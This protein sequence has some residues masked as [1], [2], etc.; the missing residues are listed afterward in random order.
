MSQKNQLRDALKQFQVSKGKGPNRETGHY[1][2]NSGRQ[3]EKFIEWAEGR[4]VESFEDIRRR[5]VQLFREYARRL[6]RRDVKPSTIQTYWNYLSAWTG[7]CVREGH[8]PSNY[9]QLSAAK[10][11]L[12][13]T[14][15]SER[16]DEQ[17]WTDE[18]RIELLRY[19]DQQAHDA[20]DKEGYAALVPARDR[21]LAYVLSYTGIRGAELLRDPDDARRD[22]LTW[23]D[24]HLDDSRVD[25]LSKKQ[26]H[27]ERALPPQTH[28]SLE[29][30][31]RVLSPA[32]EQWPVF[33][34]A[35]TSALRRSAR[36]QLET[37]ADPL[38]GCSNAVELLEV[39]RNFDLVPPSLSTSGARSVMRRLTDDAGI[40]V[41]QADYLQPHG[42]RRGAG[43]VLV[44]EEGVDAA[45]EQLDNSARVVEEHYSDILTEEQADRTG[46]AFKN[47]E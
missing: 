13:E 28:A 37:D 18:Q 39:Y 16:K 15:G 46:S 14:D 30:L 17:S 4:G 11:P 42:A 6:A 24:I 19:C 22:G 21:A 9:A 35:D 5:G 29:R 36:E 25:V 8:L 44:L 32:S 41:S 23:V 3:V 33:P 7:W 34:T 20:I 27:D 31:K 43:R 12:P 40:E 38:A 47:R 2:R 26:R 10:E 1:R 45:A